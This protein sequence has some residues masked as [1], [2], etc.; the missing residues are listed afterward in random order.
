MHGRGGWR[1]GAGRKVGW[2]HGET[3]TIRIPMALKEEILALSRQ[4]D[5][6]EEF[7]HGG[8]CERLEALIGEWEAKMQGNEAPEWQ[9][10]RQLLGEMK[11]ILADHPPRGWGRGRWGRGHC[12]Q[13]VDLDLS[14]GC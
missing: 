8:T 11:I 13:E 6:G 1:R 12:H 4:L 2:E 9:L 14:R 3:Q 5:R 10:V 7:C